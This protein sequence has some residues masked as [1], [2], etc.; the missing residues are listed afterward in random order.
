MRADEFITEKEKLDEI[1]PLVGMAAGALAKKAV[2]SLA[3]GAV[4]SQAKGAVGGVGKGIGAI[5][6]GVGKAI[7]NTV[8][9]IGQPMGKS[10][11]TQEPKDAGQRVA[12]DRAKDQMVKPGSNINLATGGPGGPQPFKVSAVQGDNVEIEN[13][14]PAPGEPSKVVYKKNDIKKS[15]TL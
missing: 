11:P 8:G 3:K 6:G 12:L 10:E 1:L 4:G 5:A 14:K 9:K 7:G 15:M 2:G 13:P